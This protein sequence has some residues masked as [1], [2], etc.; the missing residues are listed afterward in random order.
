MSAKSFFTYKIDNVEFAQKDIRILD[1]L[2]HVNFQGRVEFRVNG[3]W[4]SVCKRKITASAGRMICITLGYMDGIIKN[5]LDDDEKGYCKTHLGKDYCGPSFD[6][7][8]YES[9]NCDNIPGLK[10]V[11]ECSKQM[12]NDCPH[13][14][15]LIIE[16]SSV[17]WNSR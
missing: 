15:D 4:G 11:F 2:G 6:P 9:I 5:P 12:A 14:Q 1:D 7:V 17:D 13:E 8:L 16:C 3:K 10:S